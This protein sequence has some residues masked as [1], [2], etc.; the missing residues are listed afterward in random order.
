MKMFSCVFEDF[1]G[2]TSVPLLRSLNRSTLLESHKSKNWWSK[3]IY[4]LTHFLPLGVQ[5]LVTGL[6]PSKVEFLYPLI[7]V[8]VKHGP[9]CPT[10]GSIKQPWG[11]IIRPAGCIRVDCTLVARNVPVLYRYFWECMTTKWKDIKL[12]V[13]IK[14]RYTEWGFIPDASWKPL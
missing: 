6:R 11:P 1:E 10:K 5:W 7:M 4:L 3:G 2:G 8:G 14:T 9:F 13:F 12:L